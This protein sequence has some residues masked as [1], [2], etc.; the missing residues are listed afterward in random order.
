MCQNLI[1]FSILEKVYLESNLCLAGGS[2]YEVRYVR[3]FAKFSNFMQK[4]SFVILF[5]KYT[6]TIKKKAISK[7]FKNKY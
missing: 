1:F 6:Q 3:E 2:I 5:K 7:K 4:V